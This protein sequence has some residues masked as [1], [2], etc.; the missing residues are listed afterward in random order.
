MES[1]SVMHAAGT[2]AD[3][4]LRQAFL[5]TAIILIVEAG[6]GYLSHS[7]ALLSDA[8]HILTDVVALGFAWFAVV[9][10][11]RPADQRRT[12]GY[13]RAGILTAMLNGAA[14]VLIVIGISY[15]AARRFLHPEPVQGGIVISAALVAIAVNA[16]I[17]VRLR[18]GGRNLNVRAAL[19]HVVGDIAASVGVI[20]A[21]LLIIFTGWLY[22]DPLISVAISAL[23]A[24]SAIRIVLDTLNVLMEGVPAGIDLEQV[25]QAVRST[26][27]VD[28]VHDLHV[29]S[30]S[31]Q[32]VALSC[33]VVVA[34]ELLAAESEHLVRRVE[35]AVC[36]RF[37]IGHTTIQVEACHP[38]T[39]EALEHGLGD[40]NHPH[41]V[42]QVG[43][44]R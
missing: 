2:D 33:H 5:L 15:E 39:G 14:L 31:G 13:H 21:G 42:G 19:L 17:A 34:E 44:T 28:S 18:G 7:L 12:Y 11:R 40:H 3:S 16:Y 25:A 24:W 37:G 20:V 22:A 4:I 6:A 30:I 8:G 36:D 26:D 41:A 27:G 9:Q 43:S 1:G 23:I 10:A 38:C 35:E 32:Q 29:W